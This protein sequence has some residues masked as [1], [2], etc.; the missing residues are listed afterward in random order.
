ML[1]TLARYTL[2]Y[3]VQVFFRTFY[4]VPVDGFCASI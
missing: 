2:F 4:T 1:Y 3:K